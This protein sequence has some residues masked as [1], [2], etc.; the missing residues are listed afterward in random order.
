MVVAAFF[1]MVA[2][3][4]IKHILPD[5]LFMRNNI[6]Y[7]EIGKRKNIFCIFASDIY[8]R[9]KHIMARLVQERLPD[10]YC[11]YRM[12]VHFP[13]VSEQQKFDNKIND[14]YKHNNVTD[15]P[16]TRII[17]LLLRTSLCSDNI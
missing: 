11:L 7:M 10:D 12:H 16:Y 13:F 14:S 17:L 5:M 6:F 15:I 2:I 8:L 3:P 4:S 1:R 9:Y